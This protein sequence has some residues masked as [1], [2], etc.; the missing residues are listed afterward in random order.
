MQ[1]PAMSWNIQEFFTF[2]STE[3]I[4]FLQTSFYNVLNSKPEQRNL[5]ARDG[6][7]AYKSDG[8][9]EITHKSKD[10]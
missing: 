1:K 9:V 6:S 7:I 10:M 5:R 4:K 8:F 2:T 3:Q